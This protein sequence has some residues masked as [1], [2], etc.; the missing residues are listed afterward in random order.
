MPDSQFSHEN[1]TEEEIE[2]ASCEGNNFFTDAKLILKTVHCALKN[3]SCISEELNSKLDI[4]R[5]SAKFNI[6]I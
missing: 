2:D 4:I 3:H 6:I 1:F 5:N